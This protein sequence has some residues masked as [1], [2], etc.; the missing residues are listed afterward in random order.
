MANTVLIVEDD[1]PTSALWTKHLKHW[2]WDVAAVASAEEAIP[3]ITRHQPRA[4]ILD[5]MLGDVMSGWD[6]LSRLR[7]SRST[8]ALPVF[9]VSALDEPKRAYRE[10][11]TAF[12]VKPCSPHLLVSKIVAELVLMDNRPSRWEM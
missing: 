9:V 5:V 10:G 1:V 4:V 7:A 12:L 11:A 8:H 3:A 2:G 6:L